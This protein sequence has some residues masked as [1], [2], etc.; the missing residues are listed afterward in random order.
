[1]KNIMGVT[2]RRPWVTKVLVTGTCV[3]LVALSAWSND[4]AAATPR[5]PSS[6]ARAKAA[7]GSPIV[8][9]MIAPVQAS[10]VFFP[11]AEKVANAAV[12]AVNAGGGVHGHP[13]KLAFCDDKGD[14][15][16]AAA[17]ANQL[18][19][20]DHVVA[21][22]G[23]N[24]VQT[25]SI[26]PIL[27]AANV[28]YLCNDAITPADKTSVVSYPCAMG[29]S[30]Y[31]NIGVVTDS[32]MKKL[33]VV[34]FSGPV[35]DQIVQ[36]VKSGA[37]EAGISEVS[38]FQFGNS[39]DF[40]PIM[41]AAK[42]SG[43]DGVVLAVSSILSLQLMQSAVRVG[44]TTTPLLFSTGSW[45]DTDT[46]FAVKNNLPVRI[47]SSYDT[48]PVNTTRRKMIKDLKKYAPDVTDYISHSTINAW[49]GPTVFAS[50]ANA[51]RGDVTQGSVLAYLKTHPILHTGLTP[52]LN[53]RKKAPI[54]E[55]P[56]VRNVY[57][58]PT[59]IKAGQLVPAG[60]FET[61]LPGV[62]LPKACRSVPIAASCF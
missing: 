36:L 24:G 40:D 8:V 10:A 2:P 12:R 9:G 11:N 35:G 41:T 27:Q 52:A 37:A 3:A 32:S 25:T 48:D 31:L 46:K 51:M 44:L 39:P 16:T 29:T 17:C 23:Q 55:E 19:N 20:Q 57:A 18:V 22:V 60:G 59:Q 54:K 30:Q 1:M 45:D 53:Y 56:R 15:G 58:Q 4:F 43:A 50:V 6:S 7:S 5:A 33:A 28:P 14:P 49:L 61:K 62:S 34:T 26:M 42:N 47:Y 13:V 38:G 21:M